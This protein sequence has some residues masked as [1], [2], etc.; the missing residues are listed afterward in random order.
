MA[1]PLP[2]VQSITDCASF[3]HTVTPFLFQLQTLPS[4]ITE[5]GR[6]WDGLKDIYLTTN[7]LVTAIAFALSLAAVFLVVSELTGNYSQVDRFWSILPAV[8]N[9]HFAIWARAHGIR[10]HSLD[11]IAVVVAIWSVSIAWSSGIFSHTL[12]RTHRSDSPSTTGAREATSTARRITD[13]RL[14]GQP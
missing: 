3:G 5:V 9:G 7:P 6:D 13:G 14:F 12:T 4:R 1:M 11:T 10:S 2:S 8:Y